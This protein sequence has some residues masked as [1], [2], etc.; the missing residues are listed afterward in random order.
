M[1]S[2]TT[3]VAALRPTLLGGAGTARSPSRS[4][5]SSTTLASRAA[6]AGSNGKAC[7]GAGPLEGAVDDHGQLVRTE[8][9]ADAEHVAERQPL[10]GPVAGAVPGVDHVGEGPQRLERLRR[11]RPAARASRCGRTARTRGCRPRS[12]A[13][14]CAPA[15]PAP[16]PGAVDASQMPGGV[17]RLRQRRGV[18]APGGGDG[19]PLGVRPCRRRHRPVL[20]SDSDRM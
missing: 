5:S 19:R 8:Q 20:V 9:V 3:D 14:R 4:R 11:R 10:V 12:P 15:L 6:A 16:G 17:G 18:A 1:R 2:I 7:D 13:P